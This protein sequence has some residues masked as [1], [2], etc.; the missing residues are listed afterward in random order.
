MERQCPVER[1]LACDGEQTLGK[2]SV[3]PLSAI[4][5][6]PTTLLPRFFTVTIKF[7]DGIS[8]GQRFFQ[9]AT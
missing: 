1:W 5:T 6:S 8:I 4:T 2:A 7:A 3:L 9:I